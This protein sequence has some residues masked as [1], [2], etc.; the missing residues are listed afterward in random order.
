[1]FRGY[2]EL[3]EAVK[4]IKG[5]ADLRDICLDVIYY[6]DINE[7]NGKRSLQFIVQDYRFS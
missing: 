2:R 3:V 6:P 1:M 5:A 7:Y 4:D